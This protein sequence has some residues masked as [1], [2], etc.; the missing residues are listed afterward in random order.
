MIPAFFCGHDAYTEASRPEVNK[1]V[2]HKYTNICVAANRNQNGRRNH[3]RSWREHP[4]QARCNHLCF[5]VPDVY[6]SQDKPD[7]SSLSQR[8]NNRARLVWFSGKCATR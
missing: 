3:R 5:A 6:S 7:M 4:L 1:L 8:S 2:L